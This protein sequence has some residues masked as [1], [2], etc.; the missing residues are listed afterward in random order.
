MGQRP[1][2]DGQRTSTALKGRANPTHTVHQT[3]PDGEPEKS[4]IFLGITGA[5]NLGWRRA[6]EVHDFWR[7]KSDGFACVTM[8][9]HF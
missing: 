7:R 9:G 8:I 1:G 2:Y 3:P 5:T 4:G 6:A